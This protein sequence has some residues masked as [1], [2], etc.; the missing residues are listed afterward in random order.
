MKING[1]FI[2]RVIGS[3]SQNVKIEYEQQQRKSEIER[4]NKQKLTI[5]VHSFILLYHL[6][7]LWLLKQIIE[8]GTMIQRQ[9][10]HSPYNLGRNQGLLAKRTN[11]VK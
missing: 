2:S 8:I 11:S 1:E 7:L 6:F 3:F 4:M 9:I 10:L 5:T